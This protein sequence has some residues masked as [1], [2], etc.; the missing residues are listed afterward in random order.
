MDRF[1]YRATQKF[2][3]LT[4]RDICA[5]LTE[6]IRQEWKHNG[7]AD[8][9]GKILMDMK[10]LTPEQLKNMLVAEIMEPN[11]DWGK[12]TNFAKMLNIEKSAKQ[13]IGEYIGMR[14]AGRPKGET[15]FLS[16]SSTIYY[17]FRGMV[18]YGAQVHVLTIHAA[19]LAV[20]PSLKS[21][22]RSVTT[23]WKGRVDLDNGLITPHDL[24]DSKTKAELGFLDGKVPHALIS[25]T[26]FDSQYGPMAGNATAREVSRRA[27]QSQ[28]HTCV[29]I[30]HSKLIAGTSKHEPALLFGEK[31]W[32]EIRNRGDIEVVVNCHPQMP[33]EQ[34]SFDIALR[35]RHEIE[36]IMSQQKSSKQ[37]INNVVSYQDCVMRLRNIIKEV[38]FVE[39]PSAMPHTEVKV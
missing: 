5:A 4:K 23:I 30:D 22:I 25:A 32:R 20:Y 14:I 27:L 9:L 11:I 13:A 38:P 26:G 17:A 8:S 1:G 37:M 16:N 19:I 10:R 24:G 31:E 12:E 18:K 33:Q 7:K 21:N 15:I 3:H 39:V 6:Q 2:K 36:K 34:A 28:T 29:L 35:S